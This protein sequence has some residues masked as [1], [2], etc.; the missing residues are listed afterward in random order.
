MKL[1][2]VHCG[3]AFTIQASQLGQKGRCPH[4][5]GEITL[6]KASDQLPQEK[7]ASNP[8][9]WLDYSISSLTSMIVHMSIF[10]FLVYVQSE[11]TSTAGPGEEVQIGTLPIEELAETPTGE[12]EAENVPRAESPSALEQTLEV[13]APVP[14]SA[15]TSSVDAEIAMAAPSA[16]ASDPAGFDLGTVGIG[17]SGGMAGGGSWDG[18]LQTLRRNGLDVVIAFDSTGSMSGEI[19]EVKEQIRKIGSTMLSLVPKTRFSLCTYRDQGDAY[20]VKGIPLT[21]D[22]RQL[23]YFLKD[24]DAGGGGDHPE[25]VQEG[26][27]WAM[28]NNKFRPAARKVIL[29]FGDAPPHADDQPLCLKLAKNFREQNKGI[30]STVTCRAKSPMPEF[31]A[32]ADAGGGEA[33]L[34]T[35]GRQ[36]VSQLTILVFGSQ[37]KDKV[38]EAFKLLE[39]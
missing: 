16:G 4:C 5:R 33:F 17:R 7:R 9:A 38:V 22:L 36:I 34:T 14:T 6:P 15:S 39:K 2:C 25:A 19:N 18:M 23:E 26:I 8:Y 3:K 30:V 28:E 27:R 29:V 13:E 1:I 24:V 21:S 20:V 10:L 35:D 12:L 31:Y 11:G 32:I 37:H